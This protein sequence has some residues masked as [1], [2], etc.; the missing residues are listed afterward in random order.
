MTTE[1]GGKP[2]KFK[3]PEDLQAKIDEYFKWADDNERPYT[4]ERLAC[5][6]DCETDT[7]RNYEA[8]D[9]YFGAIKKARRFIIASKVEKLESR[10]YA[11]AGLIFDL[12]NNAGYT[13]KH[14]QDQSDRNI[15]IIA[16]NP[17]K[18]QNESD[19]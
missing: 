7:I 5:F 1:L 14:N 4:L 11:T 9:E 8:R 17:L 16:N 2:L 12:G 19:K 13:N 10:D 3:T 6:L 18:I 15:T